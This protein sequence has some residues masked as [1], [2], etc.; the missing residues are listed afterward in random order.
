MAVTPVASVSS[1]VRLL[2]IASVFVE[3]MPHLS[4]RVYYTC[5]QVSQTNDSFMWAFSKKKN[6]TTHLCMKGIHPILNSSLKHVC[7]FSA[8]ANE[9][10]TR[11]ETKYPGHKVQK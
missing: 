10:D 4:H 8:K 3:Y 9:L 7:V 2:S 6:D 11:F 5:S 1:D